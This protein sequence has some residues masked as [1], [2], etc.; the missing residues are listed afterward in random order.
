MVTGI[1]R[2]YLV[3]QNHDL[4]RAKLD[5]RTDKKW[6]SVP[7]IE[8]G[9]LEYQEVT[10]EVKYYNDKLTGISVDLNEHGLL[11]K[12]NPNR[13]LTGTHHAIRP[14]GEV[15]DAVEKTRK[16]LT[17]KNIHVDFAGSAVSQIDLCRQN[18]LSYPIEAYFPAFNVLNLNRLTR[19]GYEK[20]FY[21]SSSHS[22][23]VFYDKTHQCKKE[24]NE[25][26]LPE[27]LTRFEIRFKDKRTVS[28][29]LKANSIEG[30]ELVDIEQVYN[31]YA[32]NRIFNNSRQLTI[33]PASDALGKYLKSKENGLKDFVNHLLLMRGGT[34][35]IMEGLIDAF[36]S[37]EA[38]RH[39][40]VS[41]HGMKRN[42]FKYALDRLK[43]Q[44]SMFQKVMIKQ[45]IKTHDLVHELRDKFN[46]ITLQKVA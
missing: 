13:I 29:N 32:N 36:G 18:S 20:G 11:V 27:T 1:D 46:L 34:T 6:V 25:V 10:R 4:T 5:S 12:F 15:M 23:G 41:V 39:E 14:Q 45:G 21:F 2:L 33:Q 37:L 22:E 19:T 30:L 38:F 35:S 3:T 31:T 42:T 44:D 16:I 40:C 26:G 24:F 28:A 9:E 17:A 8:T 7:N 43:E